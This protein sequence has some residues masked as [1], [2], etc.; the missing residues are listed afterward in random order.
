M[1][2]H[3]QQGQCDNSYS[4][5]TNSFLNTF[6]DLQ[7]RFA[8]TRRVPDIVVSD[9]DTHFVGC[10][11]ERNQLHKSLDSIVR[12]AAI[13]PIN[14]KFIPPTAPHVGGVLINSRPLTYQTSNP[15]DDNVIT[16]DY[17]L[18]GQ[19]R[20]SFAPET[21]K[22]SEYDLRKR[23]RRVEL[24]CHFLESLVQRVPAN[25]GTTN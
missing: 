14:W 8:S 12:N 17:I 22:C 23:W 5:D 4:M 6:T 1:H 21:L 15:E 13:H 18:Q 2:V 24:V 19:M 11:N 3:K 25:I 16:P 10:V 20:G 9:N 7:Y